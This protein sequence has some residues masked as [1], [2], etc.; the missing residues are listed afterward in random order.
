MSDDLEPKAAGAV[1]I[2]SWN[3]AAG[4]AN[5]LSRLADLDADVAIV[6]EACHEGRLRKAGVDDFAS[7]DW[8]GR[9]P[10]RGL[11][12]LGFGRWRTTMQAKVWD[13]RIEWTLPCTAKGPGGTEFGVVGCW[14]LNKSPRFDPTDLKVPLGAQLPTTYPDLL[15]GPAVVAGDFNNNTIW[16]KPG[17]PRNWATTAEALEGIGL[18]SAYHRFFDER[19]GEETRPTHWWRRSAETTFHIDYCFVPKHWTVTQVWVGR[20]EEWLRKGD[21]SDHA[22]LVVDVVPSGAKET[23]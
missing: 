15:A 22:P 6:P 23:A 13:Q 10:A 9:F 16:D 20:H 5:K 12:V 17:N 11:A 21:G 14:A 8:V 18:T 3:V 19:F 1:R 2:V 4:F 7:M